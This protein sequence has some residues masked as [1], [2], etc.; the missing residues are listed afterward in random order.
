[1][2]CISDNVGFVGDPVLFLYHEEVAEIETLIAQLVE[3]SDGLVC[4]W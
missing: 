1:M 3:F 4:G 2:Y